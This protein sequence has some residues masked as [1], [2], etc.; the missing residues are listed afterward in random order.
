MSNF[1]T[2]DDYKGFISHHELTVITTDEEGRLSNEAVRKKAENSAISKIIHQIGGRY[3]TQA[4]FSTTGNERDDTIIE[5]TIYY[6]AKTLYSKSAKKIV[7]DDIYENYEE[8]KDFFNDIG[9]GV[10]NAI[11]LPLLPQDSS[12]SLSEHIRFGHTTESGTDGY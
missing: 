7:P 2:E 1:L 3:D 9:K 10:V 8:A 12:E 11:G 6:T 4:I 5:Y